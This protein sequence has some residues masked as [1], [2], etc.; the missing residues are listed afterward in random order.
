MLGLPAGLRPGHARRRPREPLRVDFVIS[1]DRCLVSHH[2]GRV[3]LGFAA[4]GPAL[5]VPERVWRWIACPAPGVDRH[6]RP[7]FAPYGLRKI[8]AALQEAGFEAHVIDPDYVGYYVTHGARALLV[9]HHDFFAFGPP[10][11]EWWLITG[12]EPVNRRSF[13]SFISMPEIWEAKRRRG[14]RVIVGGPA[15][16]QWEAWPEARRRWPVDTLVEGEA[17]K[18]VVELAERVLEGGELPAKVVVPPGESPAIEEIPEIRAPASGGLVEIMRGCPRGCKFCSVTLRPLRFMPLERIER[19]VLV[20]LR[21][22]S[23]TITLHS[24]DVLLYG[25][26]V[27]R[28]RAEPLVRLHETVARHLERFEA[29]F[30]W[31]HASLAAVK[32]AEEHGRAVSRIAEIIL[33][34]DVRRF[35]GVEVGIETGSPR[36][37]A[38]IMPAKAAPYR[39]EEW[40]QVVEDAFSILADNNIIPA[41][42]FILGLPGE[43]E[44]DVY[45]TI[46]LIE[47]LKPYPSLIVPMFF[48]PMGALRDAEAFRRSH[49]K[50]YHVEAMLAAARHTIRWAR[51]IMEMGYLRGPH[52]AP[53]RLA[54]A[55]FIHYAERKIEAAAR[56]LTPEAPA[57]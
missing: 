25:A 12:R 51:R 21:G 15:V 49:L 44:E 41:A 24:E 13:I 42:T 8:E 3:F 11:N 32:Y 43:T 9:G 46:D 39:V 40:P 10:S 34:G 19:E 47:R 30:S 55:A 18:V 1:T 5:G 22:G 29:G 45:K 6:G 4:T 20:N 36:L 50:P 31:S 38:R 7:R 57:A 54:L 14:L 56:Q 35:F 28:P 48:V 37:A 16:W 53:L 33:D 17:E 27:V 23:G 52:A 26:D 2:H